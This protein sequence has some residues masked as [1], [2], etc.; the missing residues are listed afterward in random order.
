MGTNPHVPIRFDGPNNKV[1]EHCIIFQGKE[2]PHY[3][4]ASILSPN[5]V[6][7]AAHCGNIVFIGTYFGD[8]VAV[9]AHERETDEI[10]KKIVDIAEVFNH[11]QYDQSGSPD[12][13]FDISLLK[14]KE[15]ISFS[16]TIGPPCLPDQGDFGDSSSFGAGMECY[17]SGWGKVGHGENMPQDMYGMYFYS[18]LF[19]SLIY[20]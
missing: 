10:G 14:L 8:E 17:L 16:D 13:S 1:F 19:C 15:P 12:K 9:G 20:H 2:D 6:L 11:P 18:I 7:T 3:C 5:W 4:G